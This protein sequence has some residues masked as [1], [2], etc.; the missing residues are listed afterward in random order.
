MHESHAPAVGP[1]GAACRAGCRPLAAVAGLVPS[2]GLVCL[3]RKTTIPWKGPQG[4][5][6]LL[7][8]MGAGCLC[9]ERWLWSPG[10]GRAGATRDSASPVDGSMDEVL[11][12][13]EH[14][15]GLKDYL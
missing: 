5:R 15:I 11:D 12:A 6:T 7:R 2:S 1:T 9:D 3:H 4:G 8:A 10:P 13:G 14:F